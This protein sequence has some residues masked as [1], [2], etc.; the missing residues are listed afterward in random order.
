MI[1]RREQPGDVA[2]VR[3]IHV[4]AFRRT[5]DGEPVEARLLDELRACA[6]WM[7]HLSF[8]V[9]SAGDVV[10]H[11]VCTR[12]DV[13]GVPAVGLGPIAV[14]PG[15]QGRG[16]GSALVHALVGAAD[17]TGEP[18][19]ALLGSPAY[20]GRFGFVPSTDV[21]IVA[22][23]DGWGAEFQVRT[24]TEHRAGVT[25]RFAYAAPFRSL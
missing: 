15:A 20:Y 25:G 13:G 2:T 14:W 17:A 21:G 12:G 16:A 3:G 11:A 24:L 4:Q 18:L 23:E 19:I 10:G 1:V 8:V 22:P 7:P 5:A 9:E 6:G